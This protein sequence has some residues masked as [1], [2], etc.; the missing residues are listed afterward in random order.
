LA[1]TGSSDEIRKIAVGVGTYDDV[2]QLFLF[3]Q[4]GL[5]PFGHAAEHTHDLVGFAV[6]TVAK[7]PQPTPHA[8]LGIVADG[9]CV[10]QDQV[11]FFQHPGGGVAAIAED[12]CHDLAVGKVHLAAVAL[13][14]KQFAPLFPGFRQH[15]GF[16]LPRFVDLLVPEFLHWM[17]KIAP[18]R[19]RDKLSAVNDDSDWIFSVKTGFV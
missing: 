18:W 5:Q 2:D 10:Q 7:V 16:P 17:T 3:E 11:G 8:L 4:L 19:V 15:Q 6:L 1:G 13:Q 12:G 14:V 9:A